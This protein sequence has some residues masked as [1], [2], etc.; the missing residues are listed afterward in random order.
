MELKLS[1]ILSLESYRSAA[2]Y[3]P[4]LYGVDFHTFL[5]ILYVF[6]IV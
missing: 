2:I 4:V 3:F 5:P 1:N 6:Y